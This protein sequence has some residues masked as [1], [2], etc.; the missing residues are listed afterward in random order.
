MLDPRGTVLMASLNRLLLWRRPLGTARL[1]AWGIAWLLTVSLAGPVPGDDA[2]EPAG[3]DE[4][5]AGEASAS[6][7]T[8]VFA[9]FSPEVQ[10][11]IAAG[12]RDTQVQDHLDHLCNRIGPRLTGSDNL[13]VAVEWAESRFRELGLEQVRLEPWGEV[14]VGFNRGPWQGRMVEPQE[15]TLQFGTYAWTAGTRGRQQGRALLAPESADQVAELAERLDGAWVLVPSPPRGRGGRGGR[16]GQ[17]DEARQAY[18]QLMAAIQEQP[19]LGL[20][21]STQTDLVLT[22]GNFRISWDELPSLPT[23]N[24]QQSQYQAI[25]E[26]LEQDQEVVLEFDIRNHFR[27][28]PI[29]Q[30]NVIA[31]IPGTEFPD[32]YVIVGGHIDSW[33]GATGA[34]DNAAGVSTTLEAARIL[35]GSGIAPRRTIRFMLWTGEEQGL[36]G[37]RA[38]VTANPEEVQRV[39]AVL[40]HDGGTNYVSGIRVLESM[41]EDMERIFE[42]AGL[43][44]PRTPFEV[45][46]VDALRPGSSD[47]D[48]FLRVGVPGFF[49][50][51][52]GRAVY[53]Q[54]HHTQY[55]TFEVVVPEYQQHSAL[56]IALGAFGIAQ[57]DDLLPRE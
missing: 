46:K 19:I 24:L 47:H 12:R 40:V 1:S 38:Y 26:L 50:R 5:V 7:D 4:A 11:I 49:W 42:P 52:S 45:I 54:T 22:G 3:G 29:P 51:Q 13:Q 35:A 23:I 43:L 6:L 48:S 31:D 53:R 20:I 25:V 37:S 36:L 57:L 39:S 14:P 2:D 33:D 18:D 10:A 30:Y 44:D 8:E 32:Q 34:T 56:V 17:A 28:G 9:R 55:D 16:G 15:L 27:R 41:V 21:R